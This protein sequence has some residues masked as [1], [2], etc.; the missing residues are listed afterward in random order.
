MAFNIILEKLRRETDKG[1]TFCI[2]TKQ[3]KGRIKTK[4]R[5]ELSYFL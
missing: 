5:Q 4:V 2:I 1:D 3:E